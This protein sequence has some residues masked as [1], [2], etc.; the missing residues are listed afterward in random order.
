MKKLIIA[1]TLCLLFF[2]ISSHKSVAQ[3]ATCA[4]AIPLIL[5][6]VCRD[7]TTSSSTGGALVCS[8]SL[9]TPITYF[10]FTTNAAAEPVLLDITAPGGQPCE[11]VMY[12][13]TSC[14]G[15]NLNSASSICFD[16]GEGLWSVSETYTLAPNTTYTLRIRTTIAG[17]ITICGKYYTPPN[18]DCSGA[19]EIGPIP[20]T[21]NNACH[22]A[23]PGV[24]PGQLCASTLE[25]TAFYSYTVDY[26]GISTFSIEDIL[27]D[28]GSAPN[29]NGFQIG[30]F[31]GSC[32]SLFYFQCFAGAG[33]N[34]Y[35]VTDTL[36]AGTKIFVAVDGVQ[37]SNCAYSV[38]ALNAI[39]L[40]ATLK[41]FIG[42]KAA[43]GNIL[44]W[45]SLQELNNEAFELQRSVDGVN[46]K[47]ISRIAGQ[48]NSN[49][50]KTY[51]I[52]DP[53]APANSYY[54]LKQISTSGKITYSKIVRLNRENIS[55]TKILFN[56]RVNDLLTLR[57]I[58]L[59]EPALSIKIIDNTGRLIRS[60][61]VKINSGENS[62][63]INT[64][65]IS[66]G[67]YYLILSGANYQK[68]L[69][70][71]KS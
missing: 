16:D 57:I 33:P 9:N 54:R 8:Y 71:L 39:I 26:R 55:N 15:G 7:Y 53:S 6:D 52:K 51:Q 43:E 10:S 14:S 32:S 66:P 48:L 70:F 34:V 13:G 5:D 18:D 64:S 25:N 60:Q 3:G 63:N 24:V 31:T 37:G 27:C 56:N 22:K 12:N 30:F 21:D 58:D 44:K 61:N 65:S 11:V 19:F 50:E 29:S 40:S 2:L 28:N 17:T 20:I 36:E 42:W 68:A 41:Y 45:A 35:A 1:N 46:Y 59:K 47:T 23:G 38:R 62:F 69:P 67:L 4:T 49:K